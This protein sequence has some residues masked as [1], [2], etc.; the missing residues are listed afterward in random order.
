MRR[1]GQEE[2]SIFSPTEDFRSSV[3]EK[4]VSLLIGSYAN[5]QR[6]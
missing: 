2:L 4:Y 3:L 1:R 5:H 6:F